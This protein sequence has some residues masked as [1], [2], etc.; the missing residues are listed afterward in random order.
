MSLW[1]YK[2][3]KGDVEELDDIRSFDKAK[4]ANKGDYIL[5]SE[6]LKKRKRKKEWQSTTSAYSAER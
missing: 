1:E 5:F 6:Y 4:I 3:M 2:K